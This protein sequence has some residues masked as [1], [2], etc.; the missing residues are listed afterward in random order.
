VLGIGF[1]LVNVRQV[2]RE[3]D[4]GDFR[5]LHTSAVAWWAGRDLYLADMYRAES[6]Q[7]VPNLN[8]PH[9]VGA[10]V[11]LGTLP[12]ERAATLGWVAVAAAVLVTVAVWGRAIGLRPALW[13]GGVTMASAAGYWNIK[14][15]TVGWPLAVI[16]ALGWEAMRRDRVRLGGFLIGVLAAAKLFLLPLFGYLVW[17]RNWPA[18]RMASLA[19]GLSLALGWLIGGSTAYASWLSVMSLVDW[20]WHLGNASLLGAMERTIGGHSASPFETLLDWP[21][22]VRP[23]WLIVSL[24]LALCTWWRLRGRPDVDRDWSAIVV[25]SLLMS[26]LAWCY[27]WPLAIGPLVAHFSTRGW[28]WRATAGIAACL[29]PLFELERWQPSGMATLVW[30]NANVWGLVLIWAA[31]LWGH[32]GSRASSTATGQP[33]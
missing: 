9:V 10:Y 12:V 33:V 20:E 25:A 4:Y 15:I 3:G 24:L 18:V 8:P 23:L 16:A 17:R 7:I 2:Q 13:A 31:I 29:V 28:P 27:Y 22:A 6:G 21:D 1:S 11:P 32:A 26:P 30:A 5:V 14:L 19:I